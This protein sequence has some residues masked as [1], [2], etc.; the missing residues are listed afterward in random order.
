MLYLA[1][2][3]DKIRL[4]AAGELREDLHANCG[5]ALDDRACKFLRVSYEALCK[6]TLEGGTDE[7]ILAWAMENGRELDENDVFIWNEFLR[8]LGWSDNTSETLAKRKAE[9]GIAERIDIITML[10]FIDVDEGRA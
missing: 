5:K 8:K 9:A 10:H 6:R 2:M 7:E 4:M 3:L 1:R